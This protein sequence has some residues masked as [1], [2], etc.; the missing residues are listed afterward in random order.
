ML[1][2]LPARSAG[3]P[4][5][6][7]FKHRDKMKTPGDKSA[8]LFSCCVLVVI[9]N[10]LMAS[11][12]LGNVYQWSVTVDGVV[13]KETGDHPR[14]FLWIPQN[15]QRVR[16]VVIAEQNMQEEQLF[17]DTTF[18]RTLA[19]LSFAEVWIAPAM[20]SSGEFR[21]DQGDDQNL[22]KLL[23]ALAE[24]SGYSELALAPLV[25]TGHSATAGWGFG[26]AA[27]NPARVLAVLS[28]SGTWPYFNA[29]YRLDR[30]I[31]AVPALTTKGEFEVQGSLEHGW[32]A[33]LKGDYFQKHPNS[34]FTQ[35]VEPGD[36]HFS[37]SAEKIGLID[38]YLHK[39]AQYRL[40]AQW[41]ADSMPT[42][43]PI[44]GARDGWRYDVWH[45]DSGPSAPT[46]PLAQYQGNRENSYWAFDRE[47]A[48]AIETFQ[49]N[50]GR[51]NVLI[52]YKQNGELVPP[53]PDH[54]MVHLKFDPIDDGLTFKL[55]AGFWD[56]VPSTRDGKSEWTGWLG[57]GVTTVV[58]NAPIAHPSAR[59]GLIK[60][61]V[62]EGPVAQ[63]ATDTF[64]VR[65]NRVGLNNPK[66]SGD[67]WFIATYPGDGT[68]KKM[69][70]Q[71]EMKIPVTNKHGTPQSIEFPNIAD[72]TWTGAAPASIK[73]SASSSAGLP[74]YYYVREGPA[75]VDDAGMLTFTPIPPRSRFPISI[76]VVA[77]QWGRSIEPL[78]Q[79]AP[80]VQKTFHITRQ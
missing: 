32:Y 36:G 79:T 19:E 64:A 53:T 69:V 51:E 15:C 31:D 74:V 3:A 54:A 16:A 46:A 56:K 39:A 58:Q 65:I 76:T 14:A 28:L 71:A 1:V 59:D 45:R 25:P 44:D 73:L 63:L 24:K 55:S 12:A 33:G 41:P 66:R 11:A 5:A 78:I 26:V 30:N 52:G 43:L 40:P 8:H 21:Y 61:G 7:E 72:Q 60:I 17:A 37:A 75:E 9:L 18:R 49:T 67:M 34:L 20:G 77:W 80:P 23:A 38:L 42:L 62:I 47:M 57:E 50:H 68:F 22:Q 48:Q 10:L 4:G 29:A 70:Q 27:W 35:V 2:P 13:S 6:V